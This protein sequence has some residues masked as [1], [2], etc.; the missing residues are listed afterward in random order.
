MRTN[1]CP[2]CDRL[3]LGAWRV[4]SVART[5]GDLARTGSALSCLAALD[6]AL[7]RN[8]TTLDE[9][10]RIRDACAEWPGAAPLRSDHAVGGRRSRVAVRDRRP[11]SASAKAYMAISQVWAYD[12]T[13]PIG[14]GDLWL[15]RLWTFLEV[16]G[17]LKYG[18]GSGRTILL[19]EKQ[20]QERLEDAGFGVARI[21]ARDVRDGDLLVTRILRASI[22][23][24]HARA[25]NP[26]G[27]GYIGPPPPWA[28]RG[29]LVARQGPPPQGC[30]GRDWW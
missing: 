19:E 14:C 13:G 2:P 18:P 22:R 21:A 26:S 7:H 29:A 16:D 24:R 17:D 1:A 10:A 6:A 3:I 15:D 20:R 5:I 23:G 28:E 11:L 30:G 25:A 8:L 12:A 27:V 4:T 9:V